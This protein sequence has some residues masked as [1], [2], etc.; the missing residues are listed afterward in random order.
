M[1]QQLIINECPRDAMQGLAHFVPTDTKIA[2]HNALLKVGFDR[3]D[4][5]S[6]VSPKAIPNLRDTAEVLAGLHLSQTKLLAIVA[7]HRGAT[8]AAGFDEIAFLGFPLSVSEQF[9]QRNTNKSISEALEEVATM[10][11]L[12]ISKGKKL[13]VYLSMAFGNPYGEPYSPTVVLEMGNKLIEMGINHIAVSDTIGIASPAEV[14][15][16]FEAL[17]EPWKNIEITA[18]LHAS[19]MAA[20]A[21]IEAAWQGGCRHFD[22][23]LGG[24]GGCPMAED[25]LVGNLNT[26]SVIHWAD[27]RHIETGLDRAALEA[28]RQLMPAVFGI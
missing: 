4:F 16:L 26:E 22:A 3:L 28:A 2:Y 15:N 5:G 10:Q 13:V 24:Y 17:A 1:K 8:E 27:T 12:C 18:H 19:P 6:F 25:E 7:N 9:Q 23:A 20:Q 11:N 14:Q 21:K